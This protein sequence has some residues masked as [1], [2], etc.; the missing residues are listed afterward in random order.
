MKRLLSLTLVALLA[1]ACSNDDGPTMIQPG[2]DA[3]TRVQQALLDAVSGDVLVFAEGTFEFDAQLSLTVDGVTLRGQG[4]DKTIWSFKNQPETGSSGGEG[5]KVK[6]VKGFTI[7]DLAIEDTRGDGIKVEG[8]QE[9]IF[10]RIRVEWTGGANTKN[11]AYGIY[12]VLCDNVLVEDCIAKGAS[13]AGIYLG[14]TNNA[15]MR[16]NT[17]SQNVAGL[18]VENS[19]NVDV[20][21]NKGT[22]N[23][24][25]ILVF[26]LPGLDR[27]KCENV[28]VFDNDCTAN[29]RDNFAEA[30]AIV[31]LVPRGVGVVIMAAKKV[32]VF[33]NTFKDNKSA[34]FTVISYAITGEPNNDSGFDPYYDTIYVHDN[35]FMGGGDNADRNN[36]LGIGIAV[37]L[38]EP[39]PEMLI[40][41]WFDPAKVDGNGKLPAEINVCFENNGSA[42]FANFDG[43]GLVAEP[44]APN[45][46]RDIADHICSHPKLPE[47]KLDFLASSTSG[48]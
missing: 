26:T 45:V 44:P 4:M 38:G 6:G 43:Q 22:D 27:K 33:G 30:G 34:H 36:L 9:V 47:V 8:S 21:N 29:N 19:T 1:S 15:I 20:Y 37:A 14:Q 48:Q 5:V 41:G 42:K 25:C 10:R 32:E 13:D 35:T 18:E 11:G 17:A 12:P 24:G 39:I 46:S 40:D 3:Q 23:T 16:G 7:E 2:P 28:R 31:R